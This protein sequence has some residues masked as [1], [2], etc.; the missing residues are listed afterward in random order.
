MYKKVFI[1]CVLS[2]LSQ[3]VTDARGV[4]AEGLSET[5]RLTETEQASSEP[6]APKH[7]IPGSALDISVEKVLDQLQK[8][9]EI[10]LVD[11]RNQADFERLRI[12]G[13]VHIPLFALRTK[14]F[15]KSGSVVLI[16]E[17]FSYAPL[18]RE[19]LELR[20]LGFESV[21]ILIGGLCSWKR[22]GA[23]LEGDGFAGEEWNQVS[24]SVFFAEKEN[25]NRLLVDLSPSGN[26]LVHVRLPKTVHLPFDGPASF[27]SRFKATVEKHRSDPLFSVV[28]FNDSGEGYEEVEK[29]LEKAG[30]V[31]VFY[32]KGGWN[33]YE[34]F[35][36]QQ[37]LSGQSRDLAKKSV[38]KCERCP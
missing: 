26:P 22:K 12:P 31:T 8:K 29:T 36:K 9:Q 16:N 4:L 35:V 38:R 32:L 3:S 37:D 13:S 10:L 23:P 24:P 14:P 33:A 7:E 30:D 20:R 21:R 15:L 34:T 2:V 1:L 11:V 25:E 18:E 5:V 19:C 6:S 27:F 17:G 28:L